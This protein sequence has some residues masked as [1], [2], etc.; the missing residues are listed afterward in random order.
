MRRS[1]HI[2]AV[3]IL[4]AAG[5]GGPSAPRPADP[6]V[7][8]RALAE[9]LDD[10][11]RGEPCDV[12]ARRSPPV[13]VADEEWLAGARLVGY[14]IEPGSRPV[15]AAIQVPVTLTVAGKKGKPAKHRVVYDV[16]T[17]PTRSIIR[18]D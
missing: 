8:Q 9:A 15:G 16:L 3:L 12:P 5:C 2:L 7:A 10:W 14:S 4:F 17:D 1:I 18:Q 11:K 6:E 13:R